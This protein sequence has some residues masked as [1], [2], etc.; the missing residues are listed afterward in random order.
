MLWLLLAAAA[1]GIATLMAYSFI[2]RM[3][4]MEEELIRDQQRK[5]D[6]DLAEAK[7]D[8]DR[9]REELA[10]LQKEIVLTR[11][12]V[13]R[14]RPAPPPREAEEDRPTHAGS[15]WLLRGG[16]ITLEQ[17]EKAAS[18][19]ETLSMDFIGTCLALGFINQALA[20]EAKRSD[21]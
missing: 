3:H 4:Q 7:A 20:A 19:M 9:L 21:R 10:E 5:L 1:S 16:H 13:E 11:N 18:R 8:H 17:Y 2:T 6:D 12:E 15:Q 14:S